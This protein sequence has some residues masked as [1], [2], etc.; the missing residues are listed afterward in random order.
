MCIRDR[1]ST[2]GGYINAP[3]VT[4]GS[5]DVN[6]AVVQHI[7]VVVLDSTVPYDGLLGMSF[8]DHFDVSIDRRAGQMRL[9]RR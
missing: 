6:G 5:I 9:M 4:L 2:A 3:L 7:P 1:L 8:L